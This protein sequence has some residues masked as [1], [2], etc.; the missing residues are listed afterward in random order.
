MSEGIRVTDNFLAEVIA[1]NV[2][3]DTFQ[4]GLSTD[5]FKRTSEERARNFELLSGGHENY[6]TFLSR[7]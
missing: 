1:G 6:L 2:C 5:P 3:K 7:E 4:L